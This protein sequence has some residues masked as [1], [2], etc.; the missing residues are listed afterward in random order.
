MR[1]PTTGGTESVTGW[2]SSAV[3]ASIPPTPQP[4]TPSALIIVVWLSMPSK[5]SGKT[6]RTPACSALATTLARYSRLIWC[7]MPLPGGMTRSPANWPSAQ[8]TSA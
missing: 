4:N 8:R 2:P 6:V 5:L 7:R 3:A 1:Q